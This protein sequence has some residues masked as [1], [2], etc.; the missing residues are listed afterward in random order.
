MGAS[1]HLLQASFATT[2]TPSFS[3]FLEPLSSV[4]KV[5]FSDRPF[6]INELV[7][8]RGKYLTSS[9]TIYK[10][11]PIIAGLTGKTLRDKDLIKEVAAQ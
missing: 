5:N 2:F 10:T 11:L 6:L 9:I 8:K 4:T 7:S 1:N 3:S